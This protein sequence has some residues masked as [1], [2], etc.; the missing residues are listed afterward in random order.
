MKTQSTIP[1]KTLSNVILSLCFLFQLNILSAQSGESIQSSTAQIIDEL[2]REV[3]NISQRASDLRKQAKATDGE[4][5]ELMLLE[6]IALD[7]EA[8]MRQIR[9]YEINYSHA[10]SV[11]KDNKRI[12]AVLQQ[13]AANNEN[14]AQTKYLL[15][16]SD[17][18]AKRA[19]ELM[20]ESI[21]QTNTNF[22]LGN[23]DNAL[24]NLSLAIMHQEKA[25]HLLKKNYQKIANTK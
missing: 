9:I 5:K 7:K 1:L 18:N 4:L 6:A 12:V 11:V 16:A 14:A 20:E 8:N 13:S 2:T 25:I 15:D 22:K 17:K 3:A 19:A 24:E 23:L 10:L 21:A